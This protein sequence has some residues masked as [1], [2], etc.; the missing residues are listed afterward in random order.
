MTRAAVYYQ[1]GA[2][3]K[4]MDLNPAIFGIEKVDVNLIHLAVRPQR[5]NAGGPWS[6][7]KMMGEVAGSGKE[8]WKQKG[9][10]RARV[11]S[12]RS[13]LWRHGGIT[14]GPRNNRDWSL[15]MNR[16]AF[17]K[18]LFTIL[19]DKVNEKKLVVIDKIDST[20]K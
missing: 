4:D 14:F 6:P 3:V 10:G 2:K 8:P 19:T 15:K 9:A 16:S 5:N 17:R 1:A 13:P 20:A 18:A 11:G 7:P 12:V